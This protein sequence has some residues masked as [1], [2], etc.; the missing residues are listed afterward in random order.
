VQR[1]IITR[2]IG[3]AVSA[4]LGAGLLAGCGHTSPAPVAASP[5]SAALS[6]FSAINHKD[7]AAAQAHF[8]PE[9][10]D[11]MDWGGGDT[12]TWSTF[13]HLRCRTMNTSKMEAGLYC[14]FKESAS[15]SEENPVS[16]WTISMVREKNGAWLI[17]NYGQ[18]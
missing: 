8:V 17:N 10:R 4:I 3:L 9:D 12:S 18:G 14:S 7:L 1:A 2:S 13:T 11:M 15:S 6:W 16:F 5:L